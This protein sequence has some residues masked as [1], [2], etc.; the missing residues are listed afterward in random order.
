M[1]KL[2]ANGN[3][4]CYVTPLNQSEADP[5]TVRANMKKVD[6]VSILPNYAEPF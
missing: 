1:Y 4:A 2:R 3:S 5:Q 6:E